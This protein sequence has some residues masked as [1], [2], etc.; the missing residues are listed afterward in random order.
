MKLCAFRFEIKF[1][2]NYFFL[3][4]YVTSEGAVITLFYTKWDFMLIIILSNYQHVSTA[5]HSPDMSAP[6][7][8]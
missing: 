6:N 5:L 7:P 2:E 3:E 8:N 4:N 1:L